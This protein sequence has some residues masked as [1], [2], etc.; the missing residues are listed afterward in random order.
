VNAE[1][2]RTGR[3]ACARDNG[4]RRVVVTVR[5]Q[6]AAKGYG[7]RRRRVRVSWRTV[8]AV[9]NATH[10]A[11]IPWYKDRQI[12]TESEDDFGLPTAVPRNAICRP[13]TDAY[14]PTDVVAVLHP[15]HR[16]DTVTAIRPRF[17]NLYKSELRTF[18]PPRNI[19]RIYS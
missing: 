14:D 19:I 16:C 3:Y 1:K 10:R 15:D 4:D 8:V 11:M 17:E 5:V 2:P 12:F 6:R 9:V 18:G 7:R 13:V